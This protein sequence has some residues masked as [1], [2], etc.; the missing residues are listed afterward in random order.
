MKLITIIL[1]LLL[2]LL[3]VSLASNYYFYKKALLRMYA[4]K[5]DPVGL[6]YYPDAASTE[7]P[8]PSNK[9]KPK[10]MFYGDSRALSWGNPTFD[11]YEFINRAIGGQTSI[12]IVS[13]FQ[14]HVV[15][16]Q[17]DIIIFQLCVNDL[18]MIPLFPAKEREIIENC[19]NNLQQLL[20]L[21]H[22]IKAK[23]ILSTV[24]PLGDV[25]IMR[26]AFGVR[27]KPI[28]KAIDEVNNYIH[29][30]A[31]DKTVIL[32]AYGLLKDLNS[33]DETKKIAPH[34]S[35]DWLHLNASGYEMLNK[36]LVNLL[37]N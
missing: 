11:Q 31:D 20:Q 14:Q 22:N 37:E 29:S 35:K 12:Q 16:H 24:F 28:I 5:L 13:R 30:L 36:E 10:V 3:L 25:S 6:N 9:L 8:K 27:E 19:K 1:I 33:A 4:D 7:L 15:A 23:V 18:K 21:A 17:P 34:Y 32:D 2:G 26:K